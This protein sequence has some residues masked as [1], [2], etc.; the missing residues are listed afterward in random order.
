[1][2]EVLPLKQVRPIKQSHPELAGLPKDVRTAAEFHAGDDSE[3]LPLPHD[4][5]KLPGYEKPAPRTKS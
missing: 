2:G 3:G 4:P 5:T 1:M